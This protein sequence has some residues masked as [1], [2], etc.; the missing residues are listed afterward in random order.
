[1]KRSEIRGGRSRIPLRS[2]RATTPGRAKIRIFVLVS[3]SGS[4]GGSYAPDH[5]RAPRPC[6]HKRETTMTIQIKTAMLLKASRGAAAIL[7]AGLT[8][9]GCSSSQD[10]NIAQEAITHFHEMMSAGQFE[11]IYAQSDDSLRKTTSADDLTRILSAINRKLGVAKTSQSSGWTVGFTTSGESATLRY[12][13][14]FE[15]G[16][17]TETFVYR[18]ADGKALLA[19]YNVNSQDLITN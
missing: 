15:H 8:L 11:Q 14:Q 3:T 1:M 6:L 4:A 10:I 12:T 13:T 19:G 17:G 9:A 7:I 18:F 2:M 16:K 5:R